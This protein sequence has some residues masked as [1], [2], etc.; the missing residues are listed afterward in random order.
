VIGSQRPKVVVVHPSD[1]LYGADRM[2]LQVL[3]AIR[4]ELDADVEVWLPADVE[5]GPHPLCEVLTERGIPWSHRDVPI[6]RRAYARPA[7]MVALGRS[8]RAASAALREARPDLLLCG[9][10]AS[11]ILAPLARRAGVPARVVHIQERWDGAESKVLRLLARATTARV[12]ISRSVAAAAALGDPQPVVVENC[13]EDLSRSVPAEPA[14][15]GDVRTFVVA[16]RWNRWKGH[17]TLLTAWELAGCPGRLLVLGG[18]PPVGE[19][20]DVPAAVE[21]LVSR[22]ET[23]EIVGEVAD[24]G[25]YLAQADVLVLPS[26][27]PEP[28]GLVVIEAFSL[29]RPVVASRAGGPLEIIDDGRD[30]WLYEIGEADDLARVLGGLTDERIGAAG[31]AARAAYLERYTPERFRRRMAEVL[32]AALPAS[33]PT[34]GS[35]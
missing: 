17:R 31:Q 14:G 24:P 32:G 34:T 2:L 13:V 28:F 26:D 12:A 1:E 16:S 21:E 22:P 29:G 25:P 3:A 20:V 7:G 18:P 23:V 10:S 9:T 19:R 4:D 33:V 5:H 15:T 35:R 6:L 11:L 27:D 30:G 8:C